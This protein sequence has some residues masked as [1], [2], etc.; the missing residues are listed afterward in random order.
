MPFSGGWNS[1]RYRIEPSWCAFKDEP[2]S[3]LRDCSGM[4]WIE[5]LDRKVRDTNFRWSIHGRSG[6]M[7]LSEAGITCTYGRTYLYDGLTGEKFDQ[8]VTVGVSIC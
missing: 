2:W 7:S 5:K 4:G 8:P 6:S 1:S 3:D